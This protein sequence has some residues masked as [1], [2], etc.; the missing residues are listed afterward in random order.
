MISTS[1]HINLLSA[2]A[3]GWYAAHMHAVE[4]CDAAAI[5]PFVTDDCM[6]QFNNDLPNYGRAALERAYAEYV[7][8]FK[9]V[10]LEPLNIYGRD[11]NFCAEMLWNYVRHD[12]SR[13]TIPGAVF[14]DRTP[15]GLISACRV[16][17]NNAAVFEPFL[18]SANDRR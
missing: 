3:F 17:M 11:N 15:E 10:E 1:L 12:D 6:L 14:I 13:F 7:R 16:Y 4:K 8:G 9:S 18:E 5:M 2:D